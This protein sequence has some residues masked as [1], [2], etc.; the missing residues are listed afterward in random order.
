MAETIIRIELLVHPDFHLFTSSKEPVVDSDQLLL[1]SKWD[2]RVISLAPRDDAIMFY[3]PGIP[4]RGDYPIS[5]QMEEERRNKYQ[6]ILGDRFFCFGYWEH[7][8]TETLISRL[9]EKNFTYDSSTCRLVAYGEYLDFCVKSWGRLTREALNIPGRHHTT[10]PILSV[11]S[12]KK[13][14]GP[15][16][17]IYQLT[18]LYNGSYG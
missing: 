11:K 4:L 3:F 10:L 6:E 2:K 9:E 13:S 17:D 14:G 15:I 16:S 12:S 5:E 18:N 7:P 8:D 1:R